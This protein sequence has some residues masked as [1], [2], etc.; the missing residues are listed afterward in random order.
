MAPGEADDVDF[1]DRLEELQEE[2]ERLNGEA[3]LLQSRIGQN[4]AELLA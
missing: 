3:T 2:L 4:V 1:R